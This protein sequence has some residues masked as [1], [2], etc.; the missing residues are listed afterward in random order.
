MQT[1][2]E[3]DK[4]AMLAL[5]YIRRSG[6]DGMSGYGTLISAIEGISSRQAAK[7]VID[8]LKEY[9]FVT[10]ES[11]PG[12]PARVMLTKPGAMRAA[13]IATTLCSVDGDG[14]ESGF[15][16]PI[17]VHYVTVTLKV[18]NGGS[19]PRDWRAQ[20]FEQHKLDWLYSVQNDSFGGMVPALSGTRL[21]FY[22]RSVDVILK[23]SA[24]GYD[25]DGVVR[26]VHENIEDAIEW[27]NRR[28]PV[29]VSPWKGS[30]STTHAA[31]VNHPFAQ[32]IHRLGCSKD[33]FTI[34]DRETGRKRAGIEQSNVFPEL[35]CYGAD[36]AV[37]DL[38]ELFQKWYGAQIHEPELFDFMLEDA[39][40]RMNIKN[41]KISND[42]RGDGDTPEGISEA[43][44]IGG[45]HGK[46]SGAPD[47]SGYRD[48]EF[49]EA[50]GDRVVW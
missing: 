22:R 1:Q 36:T 47:S 9:G 23:R 15:P 11:T 13:S 34:V 25:P 44:R 26:Q 2:L 33:D 49:M 29:K 3:N 39:R 7:R 42:A 6:D 10:V 18:E 14:L 37:E 31:L 16:A 48:K 24:S 35:E 50:W 20:F 45:S 4:S 17:D 38:R 21:I 41:N 12:N 43:E 30:I 32:M 27:V 8:R 19:L 46:P 5:D 40:E 28:T